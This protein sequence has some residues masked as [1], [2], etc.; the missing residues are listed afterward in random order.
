MLAGLAVEVCYAE[1]SRAKAAWISSAIPG[2]RASE[3]AYDASVHN[4]L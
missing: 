3:I 2:N 1:L 4:I